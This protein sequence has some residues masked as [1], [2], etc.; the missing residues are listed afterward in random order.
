MICSIWKERTFD[1]AHHLPM[2]PPGHKCHRLHGHTYMVRVE[3]A[4]E[5]DPTLQWVMDLG[6]LAA[7]M[8][9]L[10]QQLDH[11]TLNEVEGLE[12]PTAEVIA[13]WFAVRLDKALPVAVNLRSV[14]IQETPTSGARVT[15]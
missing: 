2:L 14:E 10:I 4:G 1:A 6:G 15:L 8:D 13:N 9:A 7:V 3:V 12:C 11:R 5:M